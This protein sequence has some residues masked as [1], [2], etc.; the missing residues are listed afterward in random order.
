MAL[1]AV[2][3]SDS[4]RGGENISRLRHTIE[5]A[6]ALR[7]KAIDC[8]TTTVFRILNGD[9]D[10]IPGFFVDRYGDWAV[11][12]ECR[13]KDMAIRRQVFA[14]LIDAWNL[15]GVYEKGP[16][17][18]GYHPG[19]A[20][21]DA[22]VMG[23]AAPTEFRVLENGMALIAR[24]RE[25]AKPGVYPDQRENRLYLQPLMK[26]SAVLNLFSYTGAF[27]VW[28]ALSGARETV[29]VD[30]SKRVLEWSRFNFEANNIDLAAHRHVKADAFDYLGLAQ[31]KGF[32]FDL[33]ILD[34]PT[35]STNSRGLFR[36][37]RDWPLLIDAACKVL[38]RGGRLAVSCNTH[39]ISRRKMLAL[40]GAGI[41][42]KRRHVVK[43]EAVLGLPADFPISPNAPAMNTLQFIVTRPIR[44]R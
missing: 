41:D 40:I 36:A 28:A 23:E 15:K 39:H 31:R 8:T 20:G 43:P 10:G 38:E 37:Q 6:R 16:A 1:S 25:G 27:S 11:S 34:P 9:G 33:V 7:L 42:G 35:F 26:G 5:G 14:A 4:R 30:L 44:F 24:L 29:S 2:P 3:G 32:R 19:Q 12:I 13:E 18:A 21:E 17:R 22:P